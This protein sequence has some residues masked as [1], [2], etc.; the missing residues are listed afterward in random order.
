LEDQWLEI[1]KR[2]MVGKER[3]KSSKEKA[4]DKPVNTSAD[5][6]FRLITTITQPTVLAISIFVNYKN[7]PRY[8]S[9]AGIF[10]FLKL[11]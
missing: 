1:E 6:L 2:T 3:K 11:N 4:N 7:P 9:K 5:K 10:L 8:K